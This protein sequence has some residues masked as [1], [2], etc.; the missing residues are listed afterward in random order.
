MLAVMDD[1]HSNLAALEVVFERIEKAGITKI[2]CCGDIV[3]YGAEPNECCDFV[4]ENKL[5][6][7][8]GNHDY[9]AATLKETELFNP[10]AQ[11][12]IIWTSGKLTEENRKFLSK[13]PEKKEFGFNGKKV[14]LVHGSPENT[15]WDYVWPTTSESILKK[16]L[17]KT[18]ADIL[19]LGHTH[20]PFVR[21]IDNKL[22]LNPGAIGQ[23]RDQNPCASFALINDALKIKI[24][25][26]P[27]DV[28]RTAYGII[29]AGLPRF[30]AERLYGGI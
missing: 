12:A 13:L 21:K 24:M 20:M 1:I 18:K 29:N 6:C 5:P 28:S 14:V 30:L 7:A 25:R 3:G 23:P 9:T 27:Y 17:E 16:F 8:M 26:V 19:V 4:R 2:V 15:R 22:V 10:Y 11:R